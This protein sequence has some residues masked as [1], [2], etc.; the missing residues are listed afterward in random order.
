MHTLRAP[1]L[2]LTPNRRQ[3]HSTSSE[4]CNEHTAPLAAPRRRSRRATPLDAAPASRPQNLKSDDPFDFLAALASALAAIL[5]FWFAACAATRSEKSSR[6][7][8]AWVFSESA[9]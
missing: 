6:F 3:T 8:A 1:Q 2:R 4:S 5:R 7:E 9:F